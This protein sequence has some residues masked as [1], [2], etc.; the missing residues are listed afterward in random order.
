MQLLYI[1]HHHHDMN[2]Y[3]WL[4]YCQLAARLVSNLLNDHQATRPCRRC[5]NLMVMMIIVVI[6]VVMMVMMVA[7]DNSFAHFVSEH[8]IPLIAAKIPQFTYHQWQEF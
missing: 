6:M 7:D 8:K 1:N 2:M 4:G 3:E 5:R